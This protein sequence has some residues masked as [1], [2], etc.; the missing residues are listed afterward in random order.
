MSTHNLLKSH[1]H[2]KL[3]MEFKNDCRIWKTFLESSDLRN[4]VCRPLVDLNTSLIAEKLRFFTDASA[5]K[6][7]GFGCYFDGRYLF[8]QWEKDFIVDHSPSIEFLELY[9]LCIGVFIWSEDLKNARVII[10][11]D[12]EMMVGMVNKFSSSCGN[13]IT[14]IRNWR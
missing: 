12:N 7:K 2:V 6:L 14:L 13:C 5:A 4:I 9:A 11:C 3:D 8:A 1:H 10:H